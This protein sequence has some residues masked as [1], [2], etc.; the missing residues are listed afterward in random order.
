MYSDEDAMELENPGYEA[1]DTESDNACDVVQSFARDL[2]RS[3][4]GTE[5]VQIDPTD[6]GNDDGFDLD[7]SERVNCDPQGF[8]WT[9]Q[10]RDEDG[11]AG[12]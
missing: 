5:H 8:Q 2:A 1:T 4:G 3:Q 6:K 12:Y 11:Y 9:D 7:R 10:P